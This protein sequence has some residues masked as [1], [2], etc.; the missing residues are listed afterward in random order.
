MTDFIGAYYDFWFGVNE[1]YEQWAKKWGLTSNTLFVL[2]A[3]HERP[4]ECTQRYICERLLLPK[5]TINTILA[6][7]E[8]KGLIFRE[9]A[10]TDKRNKLV[11]LTGAGEQYTKILLKA[12]AEAEGAALEAMSLEQRQA[13]ITTSDLFL[14]QL[15]GAFARQQEA[16][17]ED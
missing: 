7:L 5:Q 9:I 1:A 6:G 10:L 8:K 15:R 13:F 2:Y 4:Q 16:Q 17:K 14:Q 3:I 11:R 12:L